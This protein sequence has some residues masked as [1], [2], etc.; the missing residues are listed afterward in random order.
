MIFGD[1]PSTSEIVASAF[2]N[3]F[4][5]EVDEAGSIFWT[6]LLDLGVITIPEFF[7]LIDEGAAAPTGSAADVLTLQ[8]QVDI[9]LYF[10]VINGLSDVPDATAVLALYDNTD[11]IVSIADAKDS[12]DT[13]AAEA[14]GDFLIKLTG[15]IDNPLAE[16]V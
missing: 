8:D 4:D 14:E 2:Q 6:S 3:F 5:R 7:T 9:G 12:I 1:T 13:L 15:V 16:L 11:R 10:S